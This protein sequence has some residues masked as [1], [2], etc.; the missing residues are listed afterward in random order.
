MRYEEGRGLFGDLL[1]NPKHALAEQLAWDA[2]HLPGNVGLSHNVL[3]RTSTE[4]SQTIVEAILQVFSVD[5]VAD[6]ATTSGLFEWQGVSGDSACGSRGTGQSQGGWLA[7]AEEGLGIPERVWERLS[8]EQLRQKR[9]DLLEAAC[10]PLRESLQ[11]AETNRQELGRQLARAE[12]TLFI[13]RTLAEFGL[14]LPGSAGWDEEWLGGEFWEGLYQVAEE[15]EVRRLIG[16]RAEQMGSRQG[17]SGLRTVQS[18]A[19]GH[20]SPKDAA[21]A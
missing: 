12:R 11:Q 5:L 16:R 3:A 21:T 7:G 8:V 2:E 9:P 15:A 10:Q 1:Y 6:P 4:G 14:P 19:A 20:G 13:W 17:W 18:R